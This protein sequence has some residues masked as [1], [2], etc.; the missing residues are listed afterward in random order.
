MMQEPTLGYTRCGDPRGMPLC[1]IHGWGLDSTFMRP[2]ARMFPER[3]VYLIDL[4]GYGQ[5]YDLAPLS[6]DF[7]RSV[8]ALARTLPPSA[9]VIAA[10]LGALYAIKALAHVAAPQASSLI[11]VCSNARF[12]GDP[13]WPGFSSELIYKCRTLL[14]PTRCKRL[15]HLFI[16]L[17][18]IDPH[19]DHATF[20][21]E[22]LEHCRLPSYETLMNGINIAS[23]ADVRAELKYLKLPC[24]Q[25]FGAKD[26]LVPAALTYALERAQLRSSYI[27]VNSGHNP[28]LTEPQLFERI[29]REFFDKVHSFLR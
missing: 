24:L 5:S 25:L 9:D 21:K 3:D 1:I 22:N 7:E 19:A 10:S 4:P 27:F 20:L 2:I 15:L 28:Y 11:T 16:K 6:A 17:Q 14:T 18:L 26:R 29:V 23:Y 8:A 13:T 12:P